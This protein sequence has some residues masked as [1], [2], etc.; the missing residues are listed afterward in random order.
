MGGDAKAK[1]F[2]LQLQTI[3]EGLRNEE[4]KSNYETHVGNGRIICRRDFVIN[5]AIW[6]TTDSA[7]STIIDEG[8]AIYWTGDGVYYK[9]ING[10]SYFLEYG[11][12]HAY[13]YARDY[14]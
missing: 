9:V 10:V 13:M 11:A 1:G 5:D 6:F 2:Y 8:S 14:A 7:V 4:S 12:Q 3:M